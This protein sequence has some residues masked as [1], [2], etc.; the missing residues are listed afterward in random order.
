[1]DEFNYLSV[2]LS[3]ILGLA[4][5]QVLKGFRGLILTRHQVLHYWP[6]V[7]W[8]IFILLICVQSWWAMFGMRAVK[9]WGF[10]DFL[11]VLSQT[12]VTYLIAAIVFPDFGQQQVDLRA[13]Y[14]NHARWFFGLII[15]VLLIS[16]L[17]EWIL[18][19]TWPSP[20]NL[21]FHGQFM[22]LSL[23]AVSVRAPR[24]HQALPILSIVLFA[25]YIA[26][27]YARLA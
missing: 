21:L 15:G 9:A 17:K 8:A 3:I 11:V 16:I 23:V 24:L 10:L 12:I 26:L 5:T 14:F 20:V 18:A 2:L 19:G 1:M 6:S 22:L 25:L 13:H 7:L 27:L 4:V